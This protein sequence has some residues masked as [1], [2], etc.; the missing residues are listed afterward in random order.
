MGANVGETL[1]VSI[2]GAATTDLARQ[3]RDTAGSFV[4]DDGFA[5]DGFTITGASGTALSV[6]ATVSAD[7]EVSSTGNTSLRSLKLQ[8]SMT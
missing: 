2:D 8:Q 5:T 3:A 6:R 7:D 4:T 1:S